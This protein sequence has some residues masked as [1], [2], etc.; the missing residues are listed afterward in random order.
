MVVKGLLT[1]LTLVGGIVSLILIVAGCIYIVKR[2]DKKFADKPNPKWLI[3]VDY[4]MENIVPVIAFVFIFS[5]IF[6]G[7]YQSMWIK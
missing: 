5:V 2:I 4:F 1:L 7:I 6:V 3:K